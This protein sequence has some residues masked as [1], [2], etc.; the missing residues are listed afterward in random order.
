MAPLLWNCGEA[1]HYGGG[2]MRQR[3]VVS[4]MVARKEA[5]GRGKGAGGGEGE[6]GERGEREGEQKKEGE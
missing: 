3:K 5:R 6:A 2:S 4:L 1:E